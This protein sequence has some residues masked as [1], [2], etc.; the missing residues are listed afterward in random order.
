MP[1]TRKL[2]E[3]LIPGYN[4]SELKHRRL[5]E[6][7]AWPGLLSPHY[8]GLGTAESQERQDDHRI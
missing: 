7:L 6:I 1:C 4:R 8:H 2:L 5:P 3:L